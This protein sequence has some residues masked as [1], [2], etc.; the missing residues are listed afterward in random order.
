MKTILPIAIGLICLSSCGPSKEEQQAIQAAEK[1]K[2]DSVIKATTDNLKVKDSIIQKRHSDS[3][4]ALFEAAS[5]EAVETSRIEYQ[6]ELKNRAASLKAQLAA[7]E[8]SL[9]SINQWQLGRTQTEKIRQI[10]EVTLQIE[11]LKNEIADVEKQI[12]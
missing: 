9:E 12:E 4:N 1:A 5:A 11:L 3:I 6:A 7:A 8:A 2:M 10:E